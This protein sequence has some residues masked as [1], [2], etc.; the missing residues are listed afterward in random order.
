MFCPTVD[1][2]LVVFLK[3]T[4]SPLLLVTARIFKIEV[5]DRMYVHSQK[6]TF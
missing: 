5:E 1:K 3:N 4:P 6:Q 2:V